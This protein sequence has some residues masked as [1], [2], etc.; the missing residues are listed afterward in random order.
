MESEY[1]ILSLLPP[2]A[3]IAIAIVKKRVLPAL[4]VGILVAHLLLNSSSVLVSPFKMLDHMVTIVGEPANFRLILF[5]LMIGGLLKLINHANGFEAFAATLER[6]RVSIDRKTAFGTTYILG[7]GLFL[8]VW[9]NV[10]INATTV[11]PLYD[12]L[13][14]S[15]QR[16]AYFIHTIGVGVVSMVPINSWAAFY[17]GLLVVQG[18]V[19]PFKFLLESIPFMLYSWISLLL[20]LYVM[21]SGL[22]IGPMRRFDQKAYANR[23]RHASLRSTIQEPAKER[24]MGGGVEYLLV[25][26]ATLVLVVFISLYLTGNGEVAQGDGSRSVL[27]AVAVAIAVISVQLLL[28]GE[29]RF[30][31][32]EETF[33]KG[34]IEFLPVGILIVFALSLGDLT[35][36]LGTG[37]YLASLSV[38]TLPPMVLP[39]LVF[40]VGAGMSFATGTSYGTFSI[41]VPIALPLANASGI[42]CELMFGAVI[43][44]GLFGDNCSPISDTTIVTA[45][46][47]K[48]E[49]IDHVWSQF[50]YATIAGS[51]ALVG[52]LILGAL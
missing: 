51:L 52:F 27:Y 50:P 45:M 6:R 2:V 16:M 24:E 31:Q 33:L 10:L 28:R 38:E 39:A 18:V 3:T 47:A 8:E 21:F 22:T 23:Q 1:G 36:Q 29:H 26:I 15:R 11:A 5:S 30:L 20:V 41:M 7:A 14:I 42:D 13:G 43:A 25:P 4:L 17:M 32:L 35:Q 9:S 40:V 48:V 19:D 37:T 46:G 49:V 44:G 34:M 12:R